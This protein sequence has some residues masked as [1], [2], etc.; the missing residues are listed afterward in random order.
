M[1]DLEIRRIRFD[2]DGDVPFNWNA[3][4]PAFSTYMNMVSIMAI[5]FEKMLVAAVREA[6]P[7]ITD[8]RRSRGSRR[9]STSR[10]TTRQRPPPTPASTHQTP[11]RPTGNPRRSR[12][13]VRPPHGDDAA[14]LPAGLRRRPGSHLHAVLQDAARQRGH[15]V[16][17][18]RRTSGVA[19]DVALRRG[20]RTPKL[21]ADHL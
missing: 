21:G 7:L 11:P 20:G 19:A 12:R 18:R 16:P 5:C 13:L 2:L 9:L 4:N 15:P 10:G 1:T 14:E 3:D 6:M 17:T 8:T